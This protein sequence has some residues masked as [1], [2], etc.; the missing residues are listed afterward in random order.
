M[1]KNRAGRVAAVGMLAV[2]ASLFGTG[3][4]LN[5]FA[6]NVWFGFSAGLGGIPAQI[7]GNFIAANLLG[8]NNNAQ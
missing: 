1:K 6:N 3:C 4:S 2:C 7:I 5:G 8:G